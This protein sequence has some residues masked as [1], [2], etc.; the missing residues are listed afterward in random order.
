MLKLKNLEKKYLYVS[1]IRWMK[2]GN[3][4]IGR[5]NSNKF[6]IRRN[7]R[8]LGGDKNEQTLNTQKWHMQLTYKYNK[9]K[10]S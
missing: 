1:K 2:H 6:T 10:S 5:A 7:T 3:R 4:A 9:Q 8:Q